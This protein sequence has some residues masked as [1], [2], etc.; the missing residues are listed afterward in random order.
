M[1]ESWNAERPSQTLGVRFSSSL[2]FG[3][4]N[5]AQD[6]YALQIKSAELRLAR[7]RFL[8]EQDW[9]NLVLSFEEAKERLT[10]AEELEAGQRAK[11]DHER[12][13][14]LNGRSTL[15]QVL[16]Y[17]N[18]YSDAQSIR[19]ATLAELLQI[20]AQMKLYGVN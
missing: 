6:G 3:K 7:Q 15:F 12:R 10:A 14:Q 18:D 1:S 5:D 17:E 4:M 19:L 9:Q 8:A 11:L 20:A 2:A 13:R 16:T